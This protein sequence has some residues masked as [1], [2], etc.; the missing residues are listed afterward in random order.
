MTNSPKNQANT[1]TSSGLLLVISGPSGVG[2][3]T[4]THQVEKALHG[5]FSVSLTTRPKTAADRDGVDY[6]FVS[7]EQFEKARDNGELLEWAEVYPGC[8][9]GTLRKPVDEALAAGRLMILEIDVDGAVQIK[10]KMPGAFS[11]FVLPPNE[12]TLLERLRARAREDESKIQGRFAKAKREILKAWDCGVY[13][14]F[15]VNRDLDKAVTEAV[16]LVRDELTR[17]RQPQMTVGSSL[18]TGDF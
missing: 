10:E 5:L 9:Y 12:M 6:H 14:E 13:D 7:L 8:C 18:S 16:K 2:K 1:H 3:T 4:I 17:R 11:V 15:I